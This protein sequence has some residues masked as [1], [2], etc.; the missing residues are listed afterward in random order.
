MSTYN[1]I[2][3]I[4]QQIWSYPDSVIATD[5]CLSG[6]G[7]YSRNLGYFFHTPYPASIMSNNYNINVLELW[8]VIIALELWGDKLQ[9]HRVQ[10]FCDN[11]PSVTLINSGRTRGSL[12]S[13]CLREIAYLCSV[14]EMEVRACHI[15]SEAN[16]LADYSSR[17]VTDNENLYKFLK[18]AD[19]QT[20]EVKVPNELF[21]FKADW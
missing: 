14:C 19:F 11:Q 3:M 12:T 18:E 20:Q 5:A 15:S 8:T 1:G 9:G 10:V 2:S 16:R 17:L 7:G 4:P 6:C 21:Q 13:A